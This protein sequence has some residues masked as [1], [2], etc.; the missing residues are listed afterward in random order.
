MD[1]STNLKKLLRER[2]VSV[3]QLSRAVNVSPQTLS[4]WANSQKPADITQVKRVADYFK[5]SID[6]LCFGA[7]PEPFKTRNA[8]KDYDDEISAGIY[9]VV[10]R[11]VK[12]LKDAP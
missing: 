3:A 4:N 10:L 12:K 5:I 2:G 6:S 1:L 8:I 7:S 11:K 9:E